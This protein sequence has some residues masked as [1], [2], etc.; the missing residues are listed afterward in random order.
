MLP[1][2]PP[3]S[4]FPPSVKTLPL[5]LDRQQSTTT[6]IAYY[7]HTLGF[8]IHYPGLASDPGHALHFSQATGAGA[9][10][11][12]ETGDVGVS[13]GIVAGTSIFGISVSFGAVNS[14]ISMP[15]L[16]RSVLS[17]D[18]SALSK[19]SLNVFHFTCVV[20]SSFSHASIPAHLRAERGLPEHL[21]RLCIGIED[22]TDL[23]DDLESA[24]LSAGAIRTRSSSAM[25][26]SSNFANMT[27]PLTPGASTPSSTI[28]SSS[29]SSNNNNIQLTIETVIARARNFERVGNAS[30]PPLKLEDQHEAEELLASELKT[31]AS[32]SDPEEQEDGEN[33]LVSAPGKVILFG[34]HAVVHGVVSEKGQ[35]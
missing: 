1:F 7:L 21:I 31:K 11:S 3:P 17:P 20:S 2:S 15:C 33:V 26:S 4:L 12:F 13:E 32:V 18:S 19:A 24:L 35:A 28:S 27:P 16:M 14:L 8:S 5:R 9:V 6:L 30:L 25:N 29:A 34:E 23:I 22:P 10:L